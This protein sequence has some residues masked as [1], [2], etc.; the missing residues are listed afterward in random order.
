MVPG[1]NTR[2]FLKARTHTGLLTME[3]SRSSPGL[4]E[5][6]KPL[7]LLTSVLGHH[8][9]K[10]TSRRSTSWG[11]RSSQTFH[12]CLLI[13]ASL[14]IGRSPRWKQ[15]FDISRCSPAHTS[16]LL[17]TTFNVLPQQRPEW[18]LERQQRPIPLSSA[19]SP[20]CLRIV[21]QQVDFLT[22]SARAWTTYD[23]IACIFGPDNTSAHNLSTHSCQLNNHAYWE[24]MWLLHW[25]T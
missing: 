18:R 25:L 1:A 12:R 15:M 16:D 17:T 8:L 5:S 10:E 4:A 24:S 9:A 21:D 11:P 2:A 14:C 7:G 22:W 23:R 20:S 13:P 19:E 6:V 3:H